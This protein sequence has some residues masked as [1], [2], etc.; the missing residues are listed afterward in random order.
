MRQEK[1]LKVIANHIVDPRIV[2]T[3]NSGSDRSWVWAALDFAKGEL[4]ETIFA[5]RF[6]DSDSAKEFYDAFV[7]AQEAMKKVLEGA[8]NPDAAE[9]GDEATTAIAALSTKEESEDKP[10][11]EA[12]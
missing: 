1:T 4:V 5:L 11:Q 6:S 9:V 7:A 3:P 12:E 10:Q 2:L 8:D